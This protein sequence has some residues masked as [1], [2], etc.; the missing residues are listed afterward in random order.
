MT[1]IYQ[2]KRKHGLVAKSV[3]SIFLKF[4]VW[5]MECYGKLCGTE[6]SE[7]VV[8]V[9]DKDFLACPVYVF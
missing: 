9:G 2:E 4:N 6:L 8:G 7:N 3:Y 1:S 5:K